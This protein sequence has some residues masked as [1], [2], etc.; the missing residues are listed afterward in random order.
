MTKII[1]NFKIRTTKV[2]KK[3]PDDCPLCSSEDVNGVE[4]LG[5]YDDPLM[6]RCDYCNAF[7]LRFTERTT[8]KHLQKAKD[9]DINI[10]EWEAIWEQLPN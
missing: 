3:K 4:V 1:D 2:F 5:A 10:K 7:F 6:W 9:L 8:E